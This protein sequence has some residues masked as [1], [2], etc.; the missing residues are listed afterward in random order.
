MPFG[1]LLQRRISKASHCNKSVLNPRPRA[2]LR[3]SAA[4]G[5]EARLSLNEAVLMEYWNGQIQIIELG[6]RLQQV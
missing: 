4:S 3:D 6:R 5:L 1:V 2:L